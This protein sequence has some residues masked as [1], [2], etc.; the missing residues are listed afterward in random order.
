M[1]FGHFDLQFSTLAQVLYGRGVVH[2]SEVSCKTQAL[3]RQFVL[4][5]YPVLTLQQTTIKVRPLFTQSWQRSVR[6]QSV[7]SR[8]QGACTV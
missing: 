2:A 7:Q 3:L 4:K 6:H 5:L 8:A 1:G